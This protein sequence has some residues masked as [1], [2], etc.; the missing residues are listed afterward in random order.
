VTTSASPWRSGQASVVEDVDGKAKRREIDA[1]NG[2]GGRLDGIIFRSVSTDL[3]TIRIDLQM[4][5]TDT[6]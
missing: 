4:D 3:V 1:R 6:A 2:L 5:A